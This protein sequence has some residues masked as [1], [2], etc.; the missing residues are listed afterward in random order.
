MSAGNN[1]ARLQWFNELGF[2]LFI[3]WSIDSQLGSVIGHSMAG[4]SRDYVRKFTDE[5]PATFNPKRFDPE[6]WA[7]LARLAGMRYVV[8]TTKHHSGFC[9]FHTETTNFNIANTPFARDITGEVIDAFR[10]QGIAIGLYFSPDDFSFLRE[11]GGF[12][13]SR[14]IKPE[15]CEGLLDHNRA[16]LRELMSNYGKGDM[17]FFDGHSDGLRETAWALDPEVVVTRGAVRTPEQFIPGVQSEQPWEACVTMGTGWQYKPTNE[18]YKSGTQL[19][20]LLIETRAKGGNL[21]LNIGPKPNGELAIEQENLLREIA[22]WGFVNGEAIYRTKPWRVPNEGDVWFTAQNEG[23][24]VYAFIEKGGAW[25]LRERRSFALSS[26]RAGA[27]TT[28]RV[29][30]QA[31]DAEVADGAA[32]KWRQEGEHLQ[33]SVA[34]TQRL[35]NNRHWPNPVVL[36]IERAEPGLVPPVTVTGK[37]VWDEAMEEWLLHGE[38]VAMGDSEAVSIGFQYRVWKRLIEE[39]DEWRESEFADARMPGSHSA[40]IAGC[41]WGITY[42]FRAVVRYGAAEVYGDN[43]R[44]LSSQQHLS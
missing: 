11:K 27:E 16:Q 32:V 42:E 17:L 7:A 10:R 26:V 25:P 40:R 6:E 33:L 1:T 29:L 35:Y 34:R 24:A 28:V 8:F 37:A 30:G 12:P 15:E 18:K 41:A 36:K 43:V 5:L 19:I 13:I 20:E 21:L 22:L 9:M 38:L 2:G 31:D 44:L 4:A 39:Y 14:G 23:D 3:H